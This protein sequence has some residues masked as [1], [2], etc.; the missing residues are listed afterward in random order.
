MALSDHER[1]T[2]SS[3]KSSV[4]SARKNSLTNKP[5]TI[6]TRQLPHD[7]KRPQTP[8]STDENSLTSFPALSPSL[9]NSPV[10]S[11]QNHHRFHSLSVPSEGN[12]TSRL[13]DV[14]RH[15]AF[16][17]LFAAGSPAGER[18]SL[19]EDTP[20][21]I[22]Q[23]PGTLH[24][25]S[26][27]NLEHMIQR[28][29]A[30]TLVKRMAEDLAQR[31]AQITQ[32]HRCA[33]QRERL[34]RK[35][36]SEAE[37]SNLKIETRLKELEFHRNETEQIRKTTNARGASESGARSEISIDEQLSEAFGDMVSGSDAGAA[38][39]H[40]SKIHGN[41]SQTGSRRPSGELSRSSS[42]K[43]ETVRKGDTKRGWKSYFTNQGNQ[44]NNSDT[45]RGPLQRTSSAQERL[46]AIHTASQANLKRKDLT[47]YTFKPHQEDTESK[48]R[49]RSGSQN[50]QRA[51]DSLASDA[52]ST[53]SGTSLT[54]WASKLVGGSK[55]QS[56]L[57]D[58]MPDTPTTDSSRP[59][60]SESTSRKVSDAITHRNQ[61]AT[62]LSSQ[63]KRLS[64]GIPTAAKSSVDTKSESRLNQLSTSPEEQAIRSHAGPGP[65]EM[66]T[67]LPDHTRPPTL[68]PY[69]NT[70]ENSKYLTDRY[71]FIYDQR[72]RARQNVPVPTANRNKRGSR[73]ET[74]E[75]HRR[76]WHSLVAKD[77]ETASLTSHK[78]NE[79]VD[80]SVG[81]PAVDSP[82]DVQAPKTWQDYL[83][84]SSLSTELLSHT[85]SVAPTTSVITAD[86]EPTELKS[87][88][89]ISDRGSVVAPSST[90][91][92]S[93]TT[94]VS[95]DAEFAQSK[96][97]EA[98]AT[99]ALGEQAIDPVKALLD[100]LTDIHDTSQRE[101]ET[102]WN[103]FLR[104]IRSERQRQGEENERRL[105]NSTTVPEASWMDGEI[106]GVTSVGIQGKAGRTKWIEFKNLVLGGIPLS[107]RPKVWSEC[108]GALALRVPGYYE[109]L[110]ESRSEDDTIVAQIA[111]DIPRT[112]TDN[113]YFRTGDGMGKLS[114]VLLAYAQ[115]NPEVGYCQGMNL[116][117]GNLLLI[118]P[119]AE[120][121]F[122]ML[123]TLVEKILPNKYYD[124][125][126]LTSR[127]D[128]AVLR[129]Y[130]GT[131]LPKLSGHL[132]ELS[133]DLEALTF[134]WFLSVFTDCL[135]AE[136]L[137]RVWDV[138]LCTPPDA[139]G[140][141]TFLF[142]VALALLKLNEKELLACESSA[143]VY[144]YINGK[145][146]DHAISIDGLIKASEA[147]R[148]LIKKEEVEK[149]RDAVVQADLEMVR[150]RE[151][152]RKGKAR[153]RDI[154]HSAE[155]TRQPAEGQ[156]AGDSDR[157][158]VDGLIA[159]A[160]SIASQDE[161]EYQEELK[162]IT[163]LPVEEEAQWRG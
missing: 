93:T 85:P 31:D 114:Q 134:Q 107:L 149:R 158:E 64:A 54:S 26:E 147:L 105:K 124:H 143:E 95:G 51:V 119:T 76:S 82:L 15:G 161:D 94:V 18:S 59:S 19:F 28:V 58:A 3:R 23:V 39:Q 74:L 38:L 101:K 153:A 116:I 121:A 115:Q 151:A 61:A 130:V 13:Q 57:P 97:A 129:Q 70:G 5:G 150:Q 32:L 20:K 92:P 79:N 126:L 16:K 109:E 122:W 10:D 141:A 139:G 87:Q 80:P 106:I 103:E 77:A 11:P 25:Q 50:K 144:A 100:Q 137:F 63:G 66:D 68:L 81:S 160:P 111:M 146:T 2:K 47:N 84:L 102:R 133:I 44:K 138:V 67:I 24:L 156:D 88:I 120:D 37:V 49:Q 118:M 43:S 75:N 34:L 48:S 30:T 128:Q 12:S 125:S 35:M 117:A 132:E 99:T 55:S 86:E 45:V 69:E 163:T 52:R 22:R 8:P 14:A 145:M 29:G 96:D 90:P 46:A 98:D 40:V 159:R 72:R 56:S 9:A 73:L 110:I 17:N 155:E 71:G 4:S 78:S 6:R 65:M 131:V 89:K 1:S 104:K 41:G 152:A 123:T 140:G 33:E 60:S 162:P 113:I 83:K 21:N 142:Q 148:R 62:M 157:K 53:K 127:A 136:A 135:S 112:L 42:L 7:P 108:S 91:T 154:E 36:L 27:E